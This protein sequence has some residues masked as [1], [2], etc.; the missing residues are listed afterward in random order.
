[1]FRKG[2][3]SIP[4]EYDSPPAVIR[5]MTVHTIAEEEETASK[6]RKSEII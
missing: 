4:A 3:S 6:S 1:M 5:G 2:A